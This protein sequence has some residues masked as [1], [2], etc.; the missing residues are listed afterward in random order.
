MVRAGKLQPP[1]N[2]PLHSFSRGV[3]GGDGK[4]KAQPPKMSGRAC[5][6]GGAGKRKV[7][8]LKT[9]NDC[10]FSGGVGGDAGQG[11]V[12]PS[13]TSCYARFRGS[14]GGGCHG[15]VLWLPVRGHNP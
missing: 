13:R 1:E 15:G 10:S 8:P 6:R 3:G 14:V 9:S 12:Q 5:F 7:Q 4:R 11:K 2:E